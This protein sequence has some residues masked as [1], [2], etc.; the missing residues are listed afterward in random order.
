MVKRVKTAW[1][2]TQLL[3]LK[4]VYKELGI[5][6]T[7]QEDLKQVPTLLHPNPSPIVVELT[8]S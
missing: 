4:D 7:H 1:Q 8:G 6:H 3:R 2:T 5:A